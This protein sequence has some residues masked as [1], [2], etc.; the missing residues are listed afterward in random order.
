MF[1]AMFVLMQLLMVY[2]PSAF[3][4]C[5]RARGEKLE[6]TDLQYGCLAET[7]RRGGFRVALI[8]RYSA[9]P[10]HCACIMLL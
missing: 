2:F 4:Y 6:K 1:L 8:A 5:C 9:I 3:R 10:G 7:V